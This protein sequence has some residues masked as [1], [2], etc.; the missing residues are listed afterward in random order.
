MRA[1][2]HRLP[3]LLPLLASALAL[4]G[5]PSEDEDLTH[6]YI[7]MELRRGQNQ[8]ES[9]Y[10]GTVEIVATVQYDKCIADFYD[11]NPNYQQDGVDGELVFGSEEL[12]GEGWIDRL[13]DGAENDQVDCT[14]LEIRQQLNVQPKHLVVRYKI[15][16]PNLETRFLKVGPFPTTE[17]AQCDAGGLAIVRVPGNAAVGYDANGNQIWVPGT[18]TPSQAETNQGQRIEINAERVGS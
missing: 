11:A 12:G 13:C 10:P 2:T 18:V 14:V 15:N 3:L 1:K 5:C 17:T 4:P 7:K 6:G 8:A 16:G 9:P